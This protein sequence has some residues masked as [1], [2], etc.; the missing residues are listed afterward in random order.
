MLITQVSALNIEVLLGDVF[1]FLKNIFLLC[2]VAHPII[3]FSS[4]D[5]SV[6][7]CKSL[8]YLSLTFS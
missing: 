3:F 8:R 5:P 2:T 7:I 4:S 6:K 1:S